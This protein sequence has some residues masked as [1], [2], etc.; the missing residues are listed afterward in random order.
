M[1][2]HTS[3]TPLEYSTHILL[4]H[5]SRFSIVFVHVGFGSMVITSQGS[6]CSCYRGVFS[7]SHVRRLVDRIYGISLRSRFECAEYISTKFSRLTNRR[8]HHETMIE[9]ISSADIGAHDQ[10]M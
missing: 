2:L 9:Q 5:N 4:Q 6:I 7:S 8:T 10:L 1:N 3:D